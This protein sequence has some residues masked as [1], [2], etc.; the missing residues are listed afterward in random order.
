MKD[1]IL[2]V[3]QSSFCEDDLIKF[4]LDWLFSVVVRYLDYIPSGEAVL[5]LLHQ[6]AVL[7]IMDSDDVNCGKSSFSTRAEILLSGQRGSPWFFISKIWFMW[8]GCGG[9][10]G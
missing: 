10:V 3:E 6:A 2:L 7:L 4:R 5:S 9:R 8:V 1:L